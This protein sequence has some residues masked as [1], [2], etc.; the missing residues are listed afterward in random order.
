MENEQVTENQ[1]SLISPYAQ[2]HPRQPAA[3]LPSLIAA[4][5]FSIGVI[6]AGGS[7]AY[8]F[9]VNIPAKEQAEARLK[10]QELENEKKRHEE[11]L[12]RTSV[13]ET[14]YQECLSTASTN[15]TSRWNQHC[16]TLSTE[17]EQQYNRCIQINQGDG[18]YCVYIKRI[19]RSECQLPSDVAASYDSSYDQQKRMCLEA[20]NTTLGS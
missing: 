6:F 15:Y 16:S 5:G 18:Q 20:R 7:I 3:S 1:A 8:H 14:K 10:Q 12:M 19:P 17:R 13:A 4:I 2:P 9:L 11:S